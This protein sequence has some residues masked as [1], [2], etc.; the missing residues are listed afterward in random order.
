MGL[1]MEQKNHFEQDDHCP[2]SPW[3]MS[4]NSLESYDSDEENS[5][6]E[7]HYK[8]QEHFLRYRETIIK[9]QKQVSCVQFKNEIGLLQLIEQ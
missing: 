9:C 5:I 8:K 3:G 7:A 2:L 4:S 1:I 6:I